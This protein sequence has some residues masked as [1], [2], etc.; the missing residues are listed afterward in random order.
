[1]DNILTDA[2][3]RE[4]TKALNS[5]ANGYRLIEKAESA[6]I[7]MSEYR[8]TFDA[9]KSAIEKKKRVFFPDRP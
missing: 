1:M 2:N 3:Y 8:A 6:D 9:A 5:L 7:D 4:L